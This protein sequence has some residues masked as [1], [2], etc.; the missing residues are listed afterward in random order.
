[1]FPAVL[2]SPCIKLHLRLCVSLEFLLL[3]ITTSLEQVREFL[4]GT[5]LYVQQGH[6]CAQRSL[7]E[8]VQQCV[9]LLKDKGFITV[10]MDSHGQTM[11]V[12]KLGKA[13]YK[14]Q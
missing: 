9:D 6:L 12:T 3:Q 4:S 10:T 1:M 14:G 2:S 8:E 7:W 13:T 5:L 11:Q